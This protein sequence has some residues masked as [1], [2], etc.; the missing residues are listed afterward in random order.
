MATSLDFLKKVVNN[1]NIRAAMLTVR[2]TEGTTA[3]D[4]YNYLFGSDPKNEIRFTDFSK[5]PNID[6]QQNDYSSTA[7]GAYQILYNTWLNLCEIYGFTDF[8]ADTQDLM[9][10]ALL[11]QHNMLNK[12]VN[13][14]F[15]TTFV[16]QTLGGI[17]A[18]LPLSPYGQPTHSIKDVSS[19]YTANGG[20][21]VTV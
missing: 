19:I 11:D 16:Q 10:C 9:F 13:G 8:T 1:S 21:I 17:W 3:K 7:A 14:Y 20:E 5:H 12:V 18:S 2:T 15:M 6:R 4:G